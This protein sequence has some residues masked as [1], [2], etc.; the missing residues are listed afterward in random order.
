MEIITPVD[1]IGAEIK[2]SSRLIIIIRKL[3]NILLDFSKIVAI[4]RRAVIEI[5]INYF[6][7][8]EITPIF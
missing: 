6:R 1:V 5:N 8:A 4:L 2:I 7:R 3:R